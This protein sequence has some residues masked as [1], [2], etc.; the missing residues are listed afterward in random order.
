MYLKLIEKEDT[1]RFIELCSNFH[2]ASPFAKTNFSPEKINN[3]VGQIIA[4][5]KR[6]SI[7]ILLMSEE[8]VAQGFIVGM[9]SETP[10]GTEKI[11]MELAWWVE[12]EYRGSRKSIELLLAYKQWAKK[13]GCSTVQVGFIEGY[14]PKG[15]D[16][17]YTSQ[18]F[19]LHERGYMGVF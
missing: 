2:Q 15:L 10:F 19:K 18:G 7:V 6:E 17:L 12:E 3:L 1:D 8:G 14:S 16:R 13:V 11:A 9:T 4:S 5:D